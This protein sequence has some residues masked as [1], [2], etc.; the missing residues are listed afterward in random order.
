MSDLLNVEVAHRDNCVVLSQR[1]Y[2]DKMAEMF[3]PNGVPASFTASMTPA[4][5]EL[6]DLVEQAS[7]RRNAPSDDLRSRY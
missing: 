2:I 6:P 4:A 5:P 3:L 7:V 1:S